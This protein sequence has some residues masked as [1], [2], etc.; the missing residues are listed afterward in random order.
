MS[1]ITKNQ[2]FD[3]FGAAIL[4]YQH[5][6]YEQDITVTSPIAEDSAIS[7]PYLFRNYDQMPEWEQVAL[8]HCEGAILDIGCGA[9]SHSLWL[10]Q[11][12]MQ[13]TAIDA[14]KGAMEVCKLRGVNKIITG[15]ILQYH[16]ATYDTLLLLMNG[17]GL[18][19]KL[20]NLPKFLNHLKS[21]LKESG[22]II[23]DTSDLSYLYEGEV[24]TIYPHLGQQYYGEIPYQLHYKNRHSTPFFWLYCDLETLT[25]KANKCGLKTKVLCQGPHYEYLVALS[26]K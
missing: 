16:G 3:V 15:K 18:A 9:G 4:D 6:F 21:L 7:I 5:G 10:Q 14:S 17:I 11:Q 8:Q 19:G 24:P 22:S 26:K 23:L 12:N 25:Y 2:N 1:Q 13:V 20:Q